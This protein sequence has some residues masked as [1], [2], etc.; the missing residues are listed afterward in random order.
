LGLPF[1]YRFYPNYGVCIILLTGIVKLVTAPLT[2]T[3]FKSMKAMQKLQPEMQKL[4]QRYKDDQ[5]TLQKEVMERY[6]RHRLNPVSGCPP[7]LLQLP[8]FVGL[9]HALMHAIELRHAP[10]MLWI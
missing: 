4:R 6:Q 7:M 8:I 10:F 9:Y 5:P 1:P 3:S 2:Q